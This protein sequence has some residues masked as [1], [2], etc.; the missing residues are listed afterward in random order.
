MTYYNRKKYP[1]DGI[2]FRS[3]DEVEFYV[4]AKR[5]VEEGKL[6]D[7]SYE[8]E[9]FELIPKF[10]LNGK[11]VRATTYTPDFRL[12][13]KDGREEF[14]EV[15]GFM[16]EQALLK[17]KMFQYV[18]SNQRENSSFRILSKSYKYGVIEGTWIEYHDLKKLQKKNKKTKE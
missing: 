5:W 3:T 17:V 15:K 4:M 7:V 12:I 14:I 10:T 13:W 2:D 8:P 9:K 16:T 18:L 11:S 6:K 1:Y